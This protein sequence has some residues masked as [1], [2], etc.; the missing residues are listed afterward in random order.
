[1]RFLKLTISQAG[2]GRAVVEF[3]RRGE[4][5]LSG[6]DA[7]L[8]NAPD[9]IRQWMTMLNGKIRQGDPALSGNSELFIEP[10]TGDRRY[11]L[12]SANKKVT[13]WEQEHIHSGYTRVT[14]EKSAAGSGFPGILKFFSMEEMLLLC[15]HDRELIEQGNDPLFAGKKLASLL[16]KKEVRGNGPVF[17]SGLEGLSTSLEK[18]LNILSREIQLLE[19]KKM[20]KDRLKKETAHSVRTLNK[21]SRQ[22]ESTV[23]YR[24]T[25]LEIRKKNEQCDRLSHKISETKKDLMEL[26]E[27]GDKTGSLEKDL[28]KRFPQFYDEKS[29]G[30]PDMDRIQESFN[31]MRDLN[32]K[33]DIYRQKR[34]NISGKIIKVIAASAIFTLLS[35]GF[36]GVKYFTAGIAMVRPLLAAAAVSGFMVLAGALA[37]F[38]IKKQQPEVYIEDK[39]VREADL[40]DLLHKNNFPVA[41][42]KT[43]EIYDFL[44]QYFE[45]FI[46]FRDIRNELADLKKRISSTVT[47]A[48]KEKKLDTLNEKLDDTVSEIDRMLAGLD[49]S[50]HPLPEPGEIDNA[51]AEVTGVIKELDEKIEHEKSI[52][53]KLE[54]QFSDQPGSDVNILEIEAEMNE[55]NGRIE[56]L[57]SEADTARFLEET[58][59][60]ASAPFLEKCI[61]EFTPLLSANLSRL[62]SYRHDEKISGALPLLFDNESLLPELDLQSRILISLGVR[63]ALSAYFDE[64]DIPP[65]LLVDP[66][67]TA[68]RENVE[69]LNKI[70][71]E[72]FGNRQVIIFTSGTASGTD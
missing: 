71:L 63:S 5:I 61:E 47:F 18:E 56:A 8:K 27:I 66:V 7:G 20:K 1:M 19:L 40:F 65:V 10:G 11:K 33:I 64:F 34:K 59:S 35:L 43:G 36:A 4:T 25:L 49:Q 16:L 48:E 13:A 22:H 21:L 39:K 17:I 50:V 30:L 12:V 60:E 2:R 23:K 52:I 42:F 53:A 51:A 3:S 46:T 72:L 31:A 9:I 6:K 14:T 62:M 15:V 45:D 67:E 24:E 54:E 37:V 38:R 57:K 58:F 69:E 29:D 26:K 28:K 32:E 44:F 41:D 70:L 55:I 68:S